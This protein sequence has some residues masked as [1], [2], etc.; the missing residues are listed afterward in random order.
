MG[1]IIEKFFKEI[2][3]SDRYWEVQE[4]IR[5]EVNVNKHCESNCRQH[6]INRFLFHEGNTNMEK[7]RLQKTY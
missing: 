2:Y 5:K 7:I 6:Y 3:K 4:K 1:N